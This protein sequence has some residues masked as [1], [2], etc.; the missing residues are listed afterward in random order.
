MGL[1]QFYIYFNFIVIK[2]DSIKT[3]QIN[4][5]YFDLKVAEKFNSPTKY[6]AYLSRTLLTIL[7]QHREREHARLK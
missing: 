5:S 1:I 3:E 6:F 4:K 2:V 7:D